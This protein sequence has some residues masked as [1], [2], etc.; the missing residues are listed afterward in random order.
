MFHKKILLPALLFILLLQGVPVRAGSDEQGV[1]SL[2][3]KI[4]VTVGGLWKFGELVFGVMNREPRLDETS[5]PKHEL[6]KTIEI[7]SS[8]AI[9]VWSNNKR[10]NLS[11]LL[12]RLHQRSIKH[13]KTIL[14]LQQL[15]EDNDAQSRPTRQPRMQG[16]SAEFAGATG[17]LREIM[18]YKNKHPTG[19]KSVDK[20]LNKLVP[21]S[22]K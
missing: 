17:N 8:K 9:V 4:V 12:N 20:F 15:L 16:R 5:F 21:G 6:I 14:G 7:D 22:D 3:V 11:G 10:E 18:Q 13:E 1:I 19:L 2:M